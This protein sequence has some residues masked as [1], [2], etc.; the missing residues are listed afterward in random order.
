MKRVPYKYQNI[1]ISGGGYVTGFCY[2]EKQGT[3]Y[4][5]TDIGGIYRFREKE[6]RWDCLSLRVDQTDVTE[7]YP[8][9]IATDPEDGERIYVVSGKF[10][11][12]Q[13]RFSVSADGGRTY[14]GYDM[15][16]WVHGN[17]PGRGSGSRLLVDCRNPN[18][19]YY[20]SQTMGLW[21]TE[22]CGRHFEKVEAMPE[23][24]LT[25][26]GQSRDGKLLFVGTA[27]VSTSPKEGVG[28]NALYVSKDQ[29]KSFQPLW[30]PPYMGPVAKRDGRELLGAVA[31]RFALDDS[32]LYVTFASRYSAHFMPELAYSCDA[33]TVLDGH[34]VRYLIADPEGN[35]TKEITPPGDPAAEFCGGENFPGLAYGFAGIH[36]CP[37]RPGLLVC[38]TMGRDKKDSIWRSFDYG[39]TWEEILRG[40]EVGVLETRASYMKPKYND[41]QSVLHWMT[42]VKIHP[43]HPGEAW[44]N[45][46]TG[47]F[48]TENLLDPEV[49]F[50]DWSD[51]LEETVHLNVYAPPRGRVQLIDVLG[52]LGG[53]A[54][55]DIHK[56]CE[57]T[58]ADEADRRYITCMNADYCDEKPEL[59]LVTPRGNWSG[60]TKGGL[61]FSEDGGR[62]FAH[63]PQPYG[64]SERIDEALRNVER[65]NQNSGYCAL[66]ADGTGIVWSIAQRDLLPADLVVGSCD[67]GRSFYRVNLYDR[68]GR[69]VTEGGFK[70]YSDRVNPKLFYGFGNRSQVYL[71]RDGGRNF[72]EVADTGLPEGIDFTRIDCAENTEIRVESGAEGSIYLAAGSAGLWKLNLS[73]GRIRAVRLGGENT[74]YRLGLGL[75]YPGADYF[76]SPKA[77][78]V[79]GI[80]DGEYG[81]Y[82]SFDQGESFE[83]ISDEK[84]GFGNIQSIDADKR[85]FGRYYI[86]SGSF[87]LIAGEPRS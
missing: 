7:T 30:Q 56:E 51:G 10:Q 87:G 15:P 8:I 33:G 2:Q 47:V 43:L 52:D 74:F 5:R 81:F 48:Y 71:S 46:G 16:V 18:R 35:A 67:A 63:L 73:D 80:V 11:S 19:L 59:I 79:N 86:G 83:K 34:V 45:S 66:S 13:G 42:D 55:E 69:R 70:A 50:R 62:H 85:V 84:Q 57:N 6:K 12:K 21:K 72:W 26:V 41:G 28:G 9:A 68:E 20:A 39:E 22:D 53:F 32:Y 1:P 24:Y 44:V 31:Q 61:I 60:Q 17:L 64:L 27:G 40:R 58:F 78:Y 75:L 29:G 76:A 4:A 49:T 37:A 25:F 38:T 36:C 14:I 82:R 3:L 65:P 23:E 54:F 77:L